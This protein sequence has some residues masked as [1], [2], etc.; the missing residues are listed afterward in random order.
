ML[1]INTQMNTVLESLKLK[2]DKSEPVVIKQDIQQMNN[3]ISTLEVSKPPSNTAGIETMI[4]EA[5]IEEREKERR[6]LNLTAGGLPESTSHVPDDV[7]IVN[8][9]HNELN[10]WYTNSDQF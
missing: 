1:N 5:L 8:N 4:S 7:N 9:V 2:T 10:V 3:R 6:R